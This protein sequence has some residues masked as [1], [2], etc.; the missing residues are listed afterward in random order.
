MNN[1]EKYE[2]ELMKLGDA[3]IVIKQ[4][5]LQKSEEKRRRIQVEEILELPLTE[6]KE[7]KIVISFK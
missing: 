5:S 4:I 7:S 1:G 2:G 3:S 6:I